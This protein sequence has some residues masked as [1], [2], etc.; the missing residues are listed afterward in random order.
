MTRDCRRSGRLAPAAWLSALLIV[1]VGS[2][3]GCSELSAR[4]LIQ[5]GNRAYFEGHYEQAVDKFEQALVKAPD[6]EIAHH[7]CGLAHLKIFQSD[8]EKVDQA[9]RAIEHFQAYLR[10]SPGDGDIGKLLVKTFVDAGDYDGA[11]A[12]WQKQL[13]TDPGDSAALLEIAK[14]YERAA[15]L[16]DAL[17]AYRRRID[18][19]ADDLA[20][21]NAL[22]DVANL[23]YRRLL[24]GHEIVGFERLA[25]A[26]DGIAA[27]QRAAEIQPD[28]E[29]LP[30]M[31]AALYRQRARAQEVTWAR[32]LELTSE[33][34]H[35]IRWSKISEEKA[36]R[37]QVSTDGAVAGGGQG[38]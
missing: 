4:R 38:S 26:D 7:N 35:Q 27:L 33:L 29:Y 9:R 10:T 19:A 23:Q 34:E 18:L 36:K 25:L 11:V 12:Y 5:Q 37:Q 15:K 16:E 22:Y 14:V 13:E 21:V 2:A 28:N 3:A 32:A 6:L 8:P 17:T 24:A 30:S 20:R 31:I 1:G